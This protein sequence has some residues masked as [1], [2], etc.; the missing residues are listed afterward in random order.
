MRKV[1]IPERKQKLKTKHINF[2]FS[3]EIEINH[4]NIEHSQFLSLRFFNGCRMGKVTEEDRL[5]KS[6]FAVFTKKVRLKLSNCS[7]VFR[8][9]ENC[10]IAEQPTEPA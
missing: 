2:W 6:V 8:L 1:G 10:V 5:K 7:V 4:S 3:L 9:C